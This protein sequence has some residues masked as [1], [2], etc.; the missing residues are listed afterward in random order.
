MRWFNVG[1]SFPISESHQLAPLVATKGSSD[2]EVA[3]FLGFAWRHR[4]TDDLWSALRSLVQFASVTSFAFS[5][6]GRILLTGDRGGTIC[7]WNSASG[8]P[9]GPPV[10]VRAIPWRLSFSHDG[11]R[12]LT[13]AGKDD[14]NTDQVEFWDTA[15]MLR[16]DVVPDRRLAATAVAFH[17]NGR[18]AAIGERNGV[19]RLID[20]GGGDPSGFN[21]LGPVMYHTGPVRDVAFDPSGQLLT[22]TGDDGTIRVWA[23]PLPASGSTAEIQRHIETLTGQKLDSNGGL[24]PTADI[25]R[26]QESLR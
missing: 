7:G 26:H 10:S 21:Q 6:D 22:V 23:V 8:R 25:N 13:I 3:R 14:R 17:P 4:N 20:V 9:L 12:F 1:G 5:P 2:A 15:K 16:L 11:S 19:V 18:L 24:R